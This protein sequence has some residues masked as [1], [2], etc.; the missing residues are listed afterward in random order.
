MQ[1]W[2]LKAERET[3]APGRNGGQENGLQAQLTMEAQQEYGGLGKM[4]KAPGHGGTASLHEHIHLSTCWR[5]QGCG[6][7]THPPKRPGREEG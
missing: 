1:L 4:A 2:E 5:G 3:E 7:S 6:E